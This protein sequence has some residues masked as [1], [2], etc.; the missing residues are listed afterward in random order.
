M[1][2]EIRQIDDATW[3]FEEQGVR[4]FLLAGEEQ[5]LLIDSGMETENARE[6]AESLANLPVKLLN[7]HADRDLHAC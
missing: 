4:F 6:L 2:T 3:S 5:A 1:S 7:T